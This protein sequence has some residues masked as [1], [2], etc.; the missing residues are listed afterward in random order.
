M[1]LSTLEPA[2]RF[3]IQT[4]FLAFSF[5]LLSSC[6]NVGPGPTLV[7]AAATENSLA[8]ADVILVGEQ[9][10]STFSIDVD[11]AA[12]ARVRQALRSG[13]APRPG[14]VRVEELVNY[15]DYDYQPP[16]G[17][18][19]FAT[20]VSLGPTPWNPDTHL[21]HIGIQGREV[22][23]IRRPPANLTF[24]VDISGS[25]DGP[26]KL[27]LLLQAIKLTLNQMGSQ[28]TVA[29]VTYANDAKVALPPTSASETR[30]ILAALDSLTAAGSTAGETGINLAY[31]QAAQSFNPRAINQVVLATDGDFNVGLRSTQQLEDLIASKRASGVYLSVLTFGDSLAGDQRAQ[32]LAQNGNGVAAHIDSLSEVRR[33][34]EKGLSKA[35]P[36][37]EDVKIQIEFNPAQ[38]SA[39]RLLGYETRALR[40]E[41]FDDDSK[42]AGE[43]GAGHRVTAIYEI[44][45]AQPINPEDLRYGNA[46]QEPRTEELAFLQIRYKDPGTSASKRLDWALKTHDTSGEKV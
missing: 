22:A 19:P 1:T 2:W 34:L 4:A 11:T 21:L 5:A 20:R 29:I 14:S 8:R 12:Y 16:T 37:A 6:E 10:V 31:A 27:G 30:T 40:R 13:V 32:A 3:T 17:A 35:L 36:I 42:D 39:Y 7:S 46:N 44:S 23:Q 24:L 38:V 28:D 15:F 18:A 41:D 26:E 33:V 43:I 9:P 45:R 25:M